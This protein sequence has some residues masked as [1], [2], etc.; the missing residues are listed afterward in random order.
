MTKME[1]RRQRKVAG[2]NED[3]SS[4]S[5]SSGVR[6]RGEACSK[7]REDPAL[8]RRAARMEGGKGK[9]KGIDLEGSM[10]ENVLR[11]RCAF[12]AICGLVEE[13]NDAQKEAVRGTVWGSV[14]N[15]KKFVM[16]PHLVQALIHA[17]NPDS[18][19]F[20]VGGREVRFI[21]FDVALMT[22]LPAIG[23]EV[24]FRRGEGGGEVEQLVMMAM[25]ERLDRERRRRRGDKMESRIYRNYVAVMIDLCKQHNSVEQLPLFRKLFSLL[26]LSGL[27]F[28][29]S[30]GGSR[31]SSL[32][33]LRMWIICKSTIG[34]QLCGN[35]WL[36]PW[37]RRRRR[38][39]RRRTCK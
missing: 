17:W 8:R 34:Q 2:V 27:Y 25:E 33:W 14:L 5:G 9:G 3:S 18:T 6:L 13:L 22:G 36:M 31:G 32:S 28:P 35:S 26:V 10:G 21:Y 30:A 24:V 4:G 19:S 12:E 23:S 20:R 1:T 16:D 7:N 29:R 38:W 15:Y 11:H 39:A 37:G